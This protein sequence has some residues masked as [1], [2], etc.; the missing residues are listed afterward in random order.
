MPT[1]H[2]RDRARTGFGEQLTLCREQGVAWVAAEALSG[3]AAIACSRGDLE[4]AAR[5]LGAAHATGPWDVDPGLKAELEQRFFAAA[6]HRFGERRWLEEH[7]AGAK[8]TF[9]QAADYALERA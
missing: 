2:R 1:S 9:E 4:R 6:R 3:L 7:A 5:L 8:L